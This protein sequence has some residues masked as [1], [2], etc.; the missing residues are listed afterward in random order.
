[1]TC[2]CVETINEKLKEHNTRLTQ[3]WVLGG[4]THPGLMLQTDQI[5]TG[6]GKPKAV[7]MFL[8]Y[9]PFCGT[10]YAADEVAA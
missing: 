6:R 7:A 10:K 3:A 4:T 2:T 9:C 1:M 5:E 8:T